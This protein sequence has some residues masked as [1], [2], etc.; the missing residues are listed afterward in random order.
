MKLK[1]EHADF[2][3]A[4]VGATA[5]V[6]SYGV[7]SISGGETNVLW[8]HLV[9]P[10]IAM[11]VMAAVLTVMPF[12]ADAHLMRRIPEALG[13]LYVFGPS[14]VF[15]ATLMLALAFGVLEEAW[16]VSVVLGVASGAALGEAVSDWV[17]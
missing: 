1:P 2:A 16:W 10:L 11:G 5:I 13:L 14:V 8:R 3:A 7:I 12:E 6:F 9:L 17:A 15:G 4:L